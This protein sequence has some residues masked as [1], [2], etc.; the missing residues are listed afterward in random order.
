MGWPKRTVGHVDR[1]ASCEPR[2]GDLQARPACPWT[3]AAATKPAGVD[4]PDRVDREVGEPDPAVPAVSPAT[5]LAMVGSVVVVTAPWAVMCPTVCLPSA[6]HMALS[7]PA[8]MKPDVVMP[9]KLEDDPVVVIRPI[10]CNLLVNQECPVRAGRDPEWV[11][12][13]RSGESW[14]RRRRC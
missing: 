13:R 6:N 10:V 3:G 1:L 7:G 12:H 8:V 14:S 2:P 5:L 4:A 11:V 9:V